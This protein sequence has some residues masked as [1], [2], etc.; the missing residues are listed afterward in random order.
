MGPFA[1]SKPHYTP[2]NIQPRTDR[3]IVWSNLVSFCGERLDV[4]C[5]SMVT[6]PQ[7]AQDNNESSRRPPE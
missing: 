3:W 7:S 6:P 5:V 1:A 4:F 2:G